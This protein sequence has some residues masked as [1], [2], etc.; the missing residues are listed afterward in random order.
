MKK[1][2]QSMGFYLAVIT[3]IGVSILNIFI[4]AVTQRL[5]D[6]AVALE[7]SQILQYVMQY[8]IVI[9]LVISVEYL[10]KLALS[11]HISQR[12]QELRCI[13][14]DRYYTKTH[15][16]I[17][18][19]SSQDYISMFNNVIKTVANDYYGLSVDITMSIF[20]IVIYSI[21]LFMIN[22]YIMGVAV[23]ANVI[24]IAIPFIMKKSV[25]HARWSYLET[26]KKYNNKLSD[27]IT[28]HIT[29]KLH[30]IKGSIIHLV[31]LASKNNQSQYMKYEKRRALVDVIVGLFSFL[32]LFAILSIGVHYIT[33]NL[34]TIGA[35]FA[36]IQ[37][38]DLLVMPII[39]I[40][41]DISSFLSAKK[42][43]E[44]L[45]IVFAG[46]QEG[47]EGKPQNLERLEIKNVVASK[48][49]KVVL[50]L[51]S[52]VIEKG[53]KY[54]ILGENGSGKSTLLNILA[55]LEKNFTGSI[56]LNGGEEA[57]KLP[58]LDLGYAMQQPF[59][60]NDTLLNNITLY[61]QYDQ[62]KLDEI[63]TL[64]NLK[65]LIK[66]KGNVIYTGNDEKISGGEK[67]KIAL[68]RV[69]LA[70]KA[71]L[72]LD[73]ATSAMDAESSIA[74]ER[75]LLSKADITL[76]YIAHKTHDETMDGFDSIV[77][78]KV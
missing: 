52:L 40:S 71:L 55:G 73:E 6:T 2:L 9:V 58:P 78:M 64:L 57:Q 30:H 27:A 15:D 18:K 62:E 29:V 45:N 16:D 20:A 37:I 4:P 39:N 63:L 33:I 24:S 69:L 43:N 68:A 5:I 31:Q 38:S 47:E 72:L 26:M 49:D 53:K 22:P 42:V 14:L 28:G 54:L 25:T 35:L 66:E 59:L 21:A 41:S 76:L 13:C 23:A 51:E 75:Y 67:Q 1:Q 11:R 48:G 77:E 46:G 3:A 56:I 65:E 36:A 7:A 70:D 50:N 74:L 32:S 44:R 34:I 60:F 61:H 10:R 12:T 19:M 17:T 8:F